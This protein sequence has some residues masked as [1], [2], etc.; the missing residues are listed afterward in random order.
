MIR[1]S[2]RVNTIHYKGVRL[3]SSWE[4]RVAQALDEMGIAWVR[5]SF[6]RWTDSTGKKRRYFPDFYLPDLDV[7]LDPKNPTGVKA[8]AEKLEAISSQVTL[9][10]GDPDIILE[11]V[12]E[13]VS[14]IGFE[15][16]TCGLKVRCSP[17]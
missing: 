1:N 17:N 11:R 2:N 15:P 4:L 6:I 7:Y 8:Q 9:L 13:L 14:P 12:K 16:M 5:P 10:Y 3:D